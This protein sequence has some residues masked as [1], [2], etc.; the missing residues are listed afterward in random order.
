MVSPLY[1]QPDKGWIVTTLM[2]VTLETLI[3]IF[4]HTSGKPPYHAPHEK[5]AIGRKCH[6]LNLWALLWPL[7]VLR[8]CKSPLFMIILWLRSWVSYNHAKCLGSSPPPPDIIVCLRA[9]SHL[10]FAE[11]WPLLGGGDG[12]CW[13][14]ILF[15]SSVA[16]AGRPFP[17]DVLIGPPFSGGSSGEEAAIIV[18]RGGGARGGGWG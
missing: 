10:L 15:V 5:V 12:L 14:S 17:E 6:T 9:T 8:T 1:F 16:A 13:L 18:S 7:W 4:L 3:I 2:T 11:S